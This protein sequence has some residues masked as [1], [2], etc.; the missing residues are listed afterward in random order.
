MNRGLLTKL[1]VAIGFIAV[2]IFSLSKCCSATIPITKTPL[3]KHLMKMYKTTEPKKK[4]SESQQKQQ[5][6]VE[7]LT[8]TANKSS[9]EFAKK[10]VHKSEEKPIKKQ[11]FDSVLSESPDLSALHPDMTFSEAIN[12]FRNSTEPPL[13]IIVLWKDIETN[14]DVDRYTPIGIEPISG[15]SLVKSLELVLMAVSSDPKSLIYIVEKGTIIVGT[16]DALRR[17][18]ETHIYDIIDLLGQP[19]NYFIPPTPYYGMPYGG[20]N[21]GYGYGGYGIQYGDYGYGG[22]GYYRGQDLVG[23]IETHTSR[24]RP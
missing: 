10:P 13:N 7:A 14:S 2:N 22:P 17:K 1:A 18:P 16:R 21:G 6:K 11:T 3:Y 24:T 4:E 12:V 15:I 20:A 23:L 5:E 19:A 8:G 9:N